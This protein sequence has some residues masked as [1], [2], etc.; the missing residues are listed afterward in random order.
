MQNYTIQL[1]DEDSFSYYR[2][3]QVDLD[4]SYTYSSIISVKINADYAEQRIKITSM[5]SND[6]AVTMNIYSDAATTISLDCT[7]ILGKT[8]M[9]KQVVLQKGENAVYFDLPTDKNLKILRM[10]N[11]YWNTVKK[12]F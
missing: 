4:K 7:D 1:S 8:V 12:I 2:L 3:K 9:Q 11:D 6:N 10:S 5:I